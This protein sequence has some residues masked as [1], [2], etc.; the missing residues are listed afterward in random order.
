MTR[1]REESAMR[2]RSKVVQR[3]PARINVD[4]ARWRLPVRPPET[5]FGVLPFTLQGPLAAFG[6]E[7][8]TADKLD[9]PGVLQGI[10]TGT[11]VTAQPFAVRVT[12]VGLYGG[13]SA[14]ASSTGDPGVQSIVS[15]TDA[16]TGRS[17]RGVSS[18]AERAR[19]GLVMSHLRQ[20]KWYDSGNRDTI[21]E[22]DIAYIRY[23]AGNTCPTDAQSNNFDIVVRGFVR[24]TRNITSCPT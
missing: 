10:R 21:G 1:S 24:F 16:N 6:I 20:W 23:S 12:H 5:S 18:Y 7:P 3:Q 8:G 15:L 22:K 14:P 19:A 9:Y 11:G 13:T 4:S 17:V 2:V